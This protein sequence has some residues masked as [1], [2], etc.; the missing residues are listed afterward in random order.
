MAGMIETTKILQEKLK[1]KPS[2][3]E[4][5]KTVE[6]FLGGLGEGRKKELIKI[7]PYAEDPWTSFPELTS[8]LGGK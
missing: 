4:A 1:E 2:Y 5:I 6:K 8:T 7:N 3:E